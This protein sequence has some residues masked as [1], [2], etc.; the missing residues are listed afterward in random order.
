MAIVN[1]RGCGAEL[2]DDRETC[3]HC[4]E[5]VIPALETLAQ[6]VTDDATKELI[7][8]IILHERQHSHD[9][10]QIEYLTAENNRLQ[11]EVT[12]LRKPSGRQAEGA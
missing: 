8:K 12:E 11:G 6:N 5:D 9:Q 2:H 1:C 4:G 3:P 7:A 10:E